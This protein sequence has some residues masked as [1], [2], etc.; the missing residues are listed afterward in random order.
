M[1]IERN[2][3]VGGTATAGLMAN[4]GNAFMTNENFPVVRGIPREIVERL[5]AEGGTKPNWHRPEQPGIIFDPEIMKLV[6][7]DM[8]RE[9]GVEVLLHAFTVGAIKEDSRVVGVLIE[10]KWTTGGNRKKCH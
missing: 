8:L 9:A 1:L 7:T 5:V 2:G 3:V 4:I 6:L 10:S